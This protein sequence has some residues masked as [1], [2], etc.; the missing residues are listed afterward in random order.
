MKSGTNEFHGNVF[1]FLRND[2]LDANGFFRNRNVS[3]ARRTGFKPEHLRRHA[4]RPD[5]AQQGVLLYR[6]RRHD[7][8]RR[9]VRRRPAWLRRVAQWRLSQFPNNIVDPATG[10]PFPGKQI[11]LSRFSPVARYRCSPIRNALPAAQPGRR[12]PLGVTG[13]YASSSASKQTTTRR[14]RRSTIASRQGQPDGPLV[15]RPL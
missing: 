9:A 4:R 13:N 14:T 3:T 5:P 8:A 15:D 6:L 12:G 1:E 10:Q 7:A 2:K 11:P